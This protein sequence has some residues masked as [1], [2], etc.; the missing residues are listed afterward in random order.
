MCIRDW[1]IDDNSF[2]FSPI[3]SELSIVQLIENNS[4][5]IYIIDQG[6][7]IAQNLANKIFE[8]FY[9]D[10]QLEQDKHTGLGLSIAKKII[11]SFSGSIRL[12]NNESQHYLG[13]CFEIILP[14]KEWFKFF[15]LI[16]YDF[17]NN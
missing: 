11:E 14:L 12:T 15:I 8:R 2:S 3:G 16:I 5:I 9:T 7:G 6:K 17:I 13:A 4:V 10:R 1:A